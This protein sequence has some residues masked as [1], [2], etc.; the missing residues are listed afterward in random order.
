[1]TSRITHP[2]FQPGEIVLD[3]TDEELTIKQVVN[4]G[5]TVIVEEHPG[6]RYDVARLRRKP[7]LRAAD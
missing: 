3:E 6:R 1:M 5:W 2:Q 4:G 7:S